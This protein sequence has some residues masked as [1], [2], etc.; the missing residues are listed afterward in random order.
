[1]EEAMKVFA[2]SLVASASLITPAISPSP[3]TVIQAVAPEY[4]RTACQ[5]LVEGRVRVDVTLL[6][7][8][9][10]SGTQASGIPLLQAAAIPAALAWRIAPGAEAQQITLT[11]IFSVAREA[12]GFETPTTTFFRPPYEV[13]VRC[14]PAKLPQQG[15]GARSNNKMQQTRHG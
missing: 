4:P 2:I 14:R 5:A 1:V 6:P 13:E 9:G 15:R 10:F 11:F 8:G 7:N 12:D 3:G